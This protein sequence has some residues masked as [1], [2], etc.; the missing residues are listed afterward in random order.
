MKFELEI[1]EKIKIEKY[2]KIKGL[3]SEYKIF[4]LLETLEYLDDGE[5]MRL[6]KELYEFLMNNDLIRHDGITYSSVSR[7]YD[8]KEE[9][10]KLVNLIRDMA[11]SEDE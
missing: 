7:N 11:Y 9:L 5:S 1:K 8:K 6:D 10:S 2:V 4:D 3:K